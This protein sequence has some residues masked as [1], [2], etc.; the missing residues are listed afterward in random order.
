M[1]KLTKSFLFGATIG[2]I[3][4]LL[5]APRPGAQ[6]RKLW[7]AKHKKIHAYIA[8]EVRR[9]KKLGAK[10]YSLIVNRAMRLAEKGAATRGELAALRQSLLANWHR[11]QK[12]LRS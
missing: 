7:R 11:L 4:A 2:V 5:L 12:K 10:E 9:T 1:G 8:R 6:T 3:S